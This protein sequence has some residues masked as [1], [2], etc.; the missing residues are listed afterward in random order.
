MT[1]DALILGHRPV[2]QIR[3]SGTTP[4]HARIIDTHGAWQRLGPEGMTVE[5]YVKSQRGGRLLSFG[6]L[7]GQELAVTLSA[8]GKVG[9]QRLGRQVVEMS[10]P[11]HAADGTWRHV[12]VVLS[13]DGSEIYVDGLRKAQARGIGLPGFRVPWLLLGAAGAG[14]PLPFVGQLAELRL[15]RRPRT[16]DE[17]R[18]GM[19]YHLADDA[20]GDSAGYWSFADGNFHDRSRFGNH[21]AQISGEVRFVESPMS[22]QA[23]PRALRFHPG[24]DGTGVCVAG[25]ERY[26]LGKF[27]F[28]LETWVRTTSGGTLISRMSDQPSGFR[29]ACNLAGRVTLLLI[30]QRGAPVTVTSADAT[31]L[32]DGQW[33]HLAVRRSSDAIT[34]WLDGVPLNAPRAVPPDFDPPSETPLAF[35]A[36]DPRHDERF[37]IFDPGN[38]AAALPPTARGWQIDLAE[39]RL[40]LR[41]AVAPER[42]FRHMQTGLVGDEP[43]LGGYWSFAT[44]QVRDLTRPDAVETP[45][46]S[47]R[48]E[49]SGP[50]MEPPRHGLHLPAG[51]GHLTVPRCD[52]LSVGEGDFTLEA[53]VKLS[54]G[55]T[56]LARGTTEGSGPG[57]GLRLRITA[58]HTVLELKAANRT[59]ERFSGPCTILDDAWHRLAFS[60]RRSFEERRVHLFVDGLPVALDGDRSTAELTGTA[61]LDLGA[62]VVYDE[63]GKP[64]R[65]GDAVVGQVDAVRVWRIARSLA[66]LRAGLYQ[67]PSRNDSDLLGDWSFVA[68]APL[69]GSTFA[70]HGRLRGNAEIR[71]ERELLDDAPSP[72]A[73]SLRGEGH[74]RA[75]RPGSLRFD[76][77]HP[78]TVALWVRP[79]TAEVSARK[80]W[81]FRRDGELTVQLDGDRIRVQRGTEPSLAAR[82]PVDAGP[83][84]HV[85]A[86]YDGAR[87]RLYVNGMLENERESVVPVRPGDNAPLRFGGGDQAFALELYEAALWKRALDAHS[88]VTA[89]SQGPE[90]VS[91]QP[92]GY[93]AFHHASLRD[94]AGGG[95][96]TARLIGEAGFC[97]PD[98]TVHLPAPVLHF[99]GSGGIDCGA[100]G[101]CVDDAVTLETWV[102]LN[103]FDRRDQTLLGKGDACALRRFGDTDRITFFTA[104]LSATGGPEAGHDLPS[105]TTFN[106]GRWHHVAAVYGTFGDDAGGQRRKKMLFVDGKKEAEA[107]VTGSLGWERHR[108]HVLDGTELVTIQTEGGTGSVERRLPLPSEWGIEEVTSQPPRAARGVVLVAG[109]TGDGRW[110][111]GALDD[112]SG[113]S[114][115]TREWSSQRDQEFPV[116][117]VDDRVAVCDPQQTRLVNLRTGEESGAGL[118]L[119]KGLD[120]RTLAPTMVDGVYYCKEPTRLRAYP[121]DGA[122]EPLWTLSF[123]AP[124]ADAFG[125][126]EGV[127]TLAGLPTA[128]GTELRA[129]DTLRGGGQEPKLLWRV[130]L[131]SPY[132]RAPR[133][134]GDTIIL[135]GEDLVEARRYSPKRDRLEKVWEVPAAEALSVGDDL[136]AIRRQP[137]TAFLV[138]VATGERIQVPGE[139]G[140]IADLHLAGE[141]LYVTHEERITGFDI[142]LPETPRQAWSLSFKNAP[143]TPAVALTP[144]CIAHDPSE[145]RRALQGLMR[146]VRLWNRARSAMEIGNHYC[147]LMAHDTPGLVGYW[148]T[149]ELQP[150]R[151][152][153]LTGAAPQRSE[154][155]LTGAGGHHGAYVGEVEQGFADLVLE[156][157]R[158]RIVAHSDLMQHWTPAD[159][160]AGAGGREGAIAFRTVVKV[161]EGTNKPRPGVRV[162]VWTDEPA[163]LE[164]DGAPHPLG[165]EHAV[166]LVTDAQGAVQLV[167]HPERD[168]SANRQ[169]GQPEGL[170][171]PTIKLWADFMHPEERVVIHPDDELKKTFDGLEGSDLTH[172]AASKNPRFQEK[173]KI[174]ESLTPADAKLIADAV[175]R[176]SGS[177]HKPAAAT[178]AALERDELLAAAGVHDRGDAISLAVRENQGDRYRRSIVHRQDWV[179]D[180]ENRQA[181]ALSAEEIQAHDEELARLRISQAEGIDGLWHWF[182]NG[183]EAIKKVVIRVI[184]GVVKAVVHWVDEGIKVL[185][186]ALQEVAH[187]G[188][189]IFGFFKQVFKAVADIGKRVLHFFARIFGW[190]DILAT[191]KAIRQRFENT[192]DQLD[193]YLGMVIEAEERV[194]K[195]LEKQLEK[196]FE[197]AISALGGHSLRQVSEQVRRFDPIHPQPPGRGDDLFGGAAAPVFASQGAWLLD[198]VLGQGKALEAGAGDPDRSLLGQIGD[199][200]REL[201]ESLTHGEA[202]HS[203]AAAWDSFS[204][205]FQHPDQFLEL[206]L[207]GV[208]RTLEATVLL[209]VE[210]V[211]AA[212]KAALRLI[213]TLLG[214]LRRTLTDPIEIPVVS[215]LFRDV[216]SGGELS[217]LNLTALMV[218]I[219]TTL[220]Y[221]AFHEGTAP[222][223]AA[224]EA[225]AVKVWELIDGL[226]MILYCFIDML[227]DLTSPPV[228]PSGALSGIE[229]AS[230][231]IT[232]FGGRKLLGAKIA[233]IIPWTALALGLMVWLL[234]LVPLPRTIG[235]CKDVLSLF[236]VLIG[237]VGLLIDE[238]VLQTSSNRAAEANDL[239]TIL[240]LAL[241]IGG[242]ILKVIHGIL[243]Q[244]S[245]S[246][247]ISMLLG[248]VAGPFKVAR[249]TGLVNLTRGVSWPVN[250][251]A[252]ASTGLGGAVLVGF[253]LFSQERVLVAEL[254]A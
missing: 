17:I 188:Q 109:R 150:G 251:A 22:R 173:S 116:S 103:G 47:A 57:S 55:G 233:T 46:G 58:S 234:S 240:A 137:G 122:H 118:P 25:S 193:G 181:R 167:L 11:S 67:R 89:M 163:V 147:R 171:A 201:L 80:G 168:G 129:Y 102:R 13:K 107:V 31:A 158:P 15:W 172:P 218:A 187:V 139:L 146:E 178:A 145:P 27:D 155:A 214:L 170:S 212:L 30:P 2:L 127:V 219:P 235:T 95:S 75:P 174:H 153:D 42:L 24:P 61:P 100:L 72:A 197:D 84:I 132:S 216:I 14:D 68:G 120:G 208:L 246:E 241:G 148:A 34:L 195:D 28:T 94:W 121:L 250:V 53:T 45:L 186:H 177:I 254:A 36:P 20:L 226:A 152:T 33:H 190:T 175:R 10:E 18:D 196:P 105:R 126:H 43:H 231:K 160:A 39:I 189:A 101:Y 242:L 199:I 1:T 204:G 227:N 50:A 110:V 78:Y 26:A 128:E 237:L 185:E 154:G 9:V 180:L 119:S 96:E 38:R 223:S 230:S 213:R 222:F 86:T 136:V 161:L 134:A 114:L 66:E 76:E 238:Q 156:P 183:L 69:D 77:T 98:Q 169:T 113:Q 217:L 248:S 4:G 88:L 210:V 54:A 123:D 12:A 79:T 243:A 232:D 135:A 164:V 8:D 179:F 221:K 202:A 203:L 215:W 74:V 205:I 59:A 228:L 115:W 65:V 73:V 149:R 44:G 133:F 249:H 144:W 40:W 23:T 198:H 48:I 83:W 70:S 165:R 200:F 37:V 56:L 192:F 93:W 159:A 244:S 7:D 6:P 182:T 211:G 206:A 140:T 108:V 3:Q 209:A 124:I 63:E 252:D 253:A 184:D 97:I 62:A 52:Q 32:T 166:E 106:D 92:A 19:L 142:R 16:V 21:T 117:L 143:P 99:T 130:R 81:L 35:G 191:Q 239:G 112:A 71:V 229:K 236:L 29:L 90:Q 49:P 176:A 64:V 225:V 41:H 82:T 194:F 162:R 131:P 111:L 91:D 157:V 5:I 207:Q 60:R 151:E 247:W 85:A 125:L 245:V 104:G 138:R 87:L 224:G 51:D 220:V 141:G